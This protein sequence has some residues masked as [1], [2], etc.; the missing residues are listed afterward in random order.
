MLPKQQIFR[1][2]RNYNQ[3]VANQT[4]EDYALRF[5]AKKYRSWSAYK[6]AMTALGAA[7]FLALEAIGG[8]ITLS[9][10]FTNAVSAI[11]VVSLIIFITGLPISY[12]AARFGVDIDLLTRGA[13]FGYVGSTLTSLIYAAFTFI[14]FAIEAAILASALE[15]LFSIPLYIGYILSS[16]AVIPIVTHGITFISR[17]QIFTQPIWLIL[18]IAAIVAVVYHEANAIQDWIQ[19]QGAY[20]SQT[21]DK[22]TFNNGFDLLLFG[23]ASSILFALMAQIGEQADYLRFMP[24]QQQTSKPRWWF[25]VL[26]AG[27]GWIFIGVIKLL[28]G[29]FIAYLAFSSGLS[30]I[31]SSDP[32][33][34]YQ[35]AFGYLTHSESLPLILAGIMV[36]VCQL[37]INVTNAY[38]GSLAWSNFF[39]RLTHNHPGRVVW[40]VFN[41]II[42]LLLM[43]L[44]IYRA[45]ENI[46][47]VFAIV[48]VSWLGTVSADLSINKTL[49]LSP[50]GIEFKRAHLYDINPVGLGSLLIASVVG[51]TAY[52]GLY[53]DA[54]KALAHFITLLTTFISTPFIALL[55]KSRYYIARESPEFNTSIDNQTI[56]SINEHQCCICELYYESEDMSSCPAYQGSI[57][58][59]CCSLDTRCLDQCKH[60][61]RFYDQASRFFKLFIPSN[62]LNKIHSRFVYFIGI[63]FLISLLNGAILSLIYYQIPSNSPETLSIVAD[64]LWILFFIFLIITG[65]IAWLFLLAK[66]SHVV[67][68]EESQRQTNRLI[69]EIEAHVKTDEALQKAL[70]QADSANQAKSRYLSGISH[71]LRSPLQTILGYA[72]LLGQNDT[73]PSKPRES[74]NIIQRSS[75]YLSDLIE[76]LL[77]VSKI[78][79]GKLEIRRD[80]MNFHELMNQLAMIFKPQAEQ[81]HLDFIFNLPPKFPNYVIADEKRVRQILINVLSNAIKFTEQGSVEFSLRYKNQVAEFTISDTGAGINKNDLERIFHPF[82]RANNNNVHTPGTGLGLTIVH[83]LSDIMGGNVEVKST[84]GVG[85]QFTI[86]L[87]LAPTNS[88]ALTSSPQ[89]SIIGYRDTIKTVMIVDD[90]HAHRTL[91]SDLLTPLGFIVLE[92]HSAKRCLDML[93]QSHPDIF[94]LDVSMPEI[95]GLSLAK[96]IRSRAITTPIIMI[97]ADA[98]EH[99]TIAAPN[100]PHNAYMVKPIKITALLDKIATLLTLK[101]VYKN[102]TPTNTD[103]VSSEYITNADIKWNIPEHPYVNQLISYSEIGYAKGFLDVLT[104]AS[105]E[106][107]LSSSVIQH[108]Y[109]LAKQIRFDKIVELLSESQQNND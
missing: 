86:S 63:V 101:W 73:I 15:V 14:F 65:V 94:L 11:A 66:E 1:V 24:T 56:D 87:M 52:L 105:D 83:L 47:G 54:A 43:E 16:L 60:N 21:A 89:S 4:L 82:E 25:S 74:I 91:I 17:F 48:A 29:S 59:L 39:S 10:G 96:T 49:G 61:A 80:E 19:F 51:I 109:R 18:Q 55:T 30:I 57:C 28:L 22:L 9:Y 50:S 38:A 12:Y 69:D 6:V 104:K 46:L 103:F 84:P 41:V 36:I 37:K 98:Q 53:G 2:R 13:G 107:I 95:D 77:D 3:W 88:P 26:F 90:Q 93:D 7:A 81:K 97:S 58:S 64:A 67:A 85:S 62:I 100:S 72:Q 8:A 5:T 106:N 71:E 27:P 44:G 34:M 20:A 23:A 32:V 78:E 31:Q 45:L 79:A 92:A 75:E 40:L 42:A 33:Y 76:G 102:V 108:L 99:N 68:Q 35:V 70:K